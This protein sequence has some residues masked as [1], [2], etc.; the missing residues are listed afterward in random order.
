L[1]S[2]IVEA[3]IRNYDVVVDQVQRYLAYV[4]EELAEVN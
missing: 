4:K 2:K 1:L 3:Y